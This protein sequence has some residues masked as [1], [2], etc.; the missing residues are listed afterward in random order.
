MTADDMHHA[1]TLTAVL[2]G[3][4]PSVAA[5]KAG[6]THS[7]TL[8]ASSLRVSDRTPVSP[9]STIALPTDVAAGWYNLVITIKAAGGNTGSATVIQVTHAS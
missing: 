9:V 8:V 3:P 2:S 6:G 5:L 1:I 7:E 4:F